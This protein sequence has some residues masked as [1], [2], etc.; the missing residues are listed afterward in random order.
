[1][2][3]P[4]LIPSFFLYDDTL[5][6]VELDFLHVEAINIRSRPHDWTIRPHAHPEHFQFL[7]VIEGGGF[8]RVE[9]DTWQLDPPA[10]VV[11]P[12][13]AVHEIRFE[14]GSD[15]FVITAAT[16]CVMEAVQ[17]ELA[18]ADV[19]AAAGRYHAQDPDGDDYGMGD[20]FHWLER[21]FVGAA[22]GRRTAIRAHFQR[23]LVSLARFRDHGARAGGSAPM[24]RDAEIVVRYRRLIEEHF[25]QGLPLTFYAD[26]LNITYA[27]LN[28]ACRGAAGKSALK[29][30]HDRQMIEAKRNLLYTCM[31]IGE[32]GH[33]VGFQD[34]AYFNRFFTRRAGCAPGAFRAAMRVPTPGA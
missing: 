32:V 4:N 16:P 24:R 21:E 30:M 9:G 27:R 6:D 25:R 33:A 29:L 18:L 12:P 28:A 14:P 26:Q 13:T 15:G 1:M 23:I 3:R 5:A 34:P 19:V 2:S 31:T 20:A 7:F 8:I 17:P 22:P 10:L 11:I